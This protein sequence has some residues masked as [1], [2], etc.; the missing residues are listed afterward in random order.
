[1]RTLTSQFMC[2]MLDPV[3]QSELPVCMILWK[4]RSQGYLASV[5][6]MV[7]NSVDLDQMKPSD[8]DIP[9]IY[10]PHDDFI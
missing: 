6:D 10:K 4:I 8:Q 2:N 1:M 7:E 3:V 9:A 5:I